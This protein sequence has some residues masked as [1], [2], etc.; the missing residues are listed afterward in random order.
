MAKPRG[1]GFTLLELLVVISITVLLIGILLPQLAGARAV[2][3]RSACLSNLR[4]LGM[5]LLEYRYNN[6]GAIPEVQTLPVD[7]FAPTVMDALS[8]YAPAK[9][10]WHCPTDRELFGQVGT[11]YEYFVGFYL[12][13]I[14]LRQSNKDGK[15]NDLLHFFEQYASMAFIMTDAEAWHPGGPG[16]S[17]RCALFLDGRAD[18]F[19]LPS[20]ANAGALNP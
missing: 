1:Q 17:D 11:S 8:R 12:T 10:I 16:G 18:W 3:Q 9:A 13:M 20:G 15:K 14:D 4:Q 2:A 19:A 5:A 7:P 6:N